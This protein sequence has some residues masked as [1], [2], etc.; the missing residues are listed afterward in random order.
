MW[1]GPV[2][3]AQSPPYTQYGAGIQWRLVSNQSILWDPA[4]RRSDEGAHLL[5]TSLLS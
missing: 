4:L 3:P 2:I 1:G 5:T